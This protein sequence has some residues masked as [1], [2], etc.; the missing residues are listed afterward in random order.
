MIEKFIK[1][2]SFHDG[3]ITAM[4]YCKEL[5]C[6]EMNIVQLYS[7]LT[8]ESSENSIFKQDDLVEIELCMENVNYVSWEEI[9]YSDYE[10]ADVLYEQK[11]DEDI[12]LYKLHTFGGYKEIC[13]RGKNI[14]IS[15]QINK[16]L[17]S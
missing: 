10:I 2:N 16:K 14:K 1:T 4:K 8:I 17:D 15:A 7:E 5:Q 3:Y 6:V 13:I 12:L 9:D 11:E